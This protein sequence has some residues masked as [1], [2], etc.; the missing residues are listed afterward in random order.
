[1][2]QV[3]YI[4]FNFLEGACPI[5]TLPYVLQAR[6]IPT[7]PILFKTTPEFKPLVII[8]IYNVEPIA[9]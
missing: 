2:H 7:P 9:N 3:A 4:F 6:C 1:M 5:L 8:F